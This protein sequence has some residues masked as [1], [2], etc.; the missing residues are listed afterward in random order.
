MKTT[1]SAKLRGY[2]RIRI[3]GVEAERFL[4]ELI[5]K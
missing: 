5:A 4:N 2:V 3:Y 1:L